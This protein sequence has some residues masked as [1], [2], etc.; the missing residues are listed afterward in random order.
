[1]MWRASPRQSPNHHH[2]PAVEMT[3]TDEAGLA[4]I[5]P[6]IGDRRGAAGKNLA[7]PQEI[8]AA[9]SQRQIAFGRVKGDLQLIVPPINVKRSR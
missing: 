1:M 6:L 2:Q 3:R 8:Q 4:V 5:E 7:G 9:M